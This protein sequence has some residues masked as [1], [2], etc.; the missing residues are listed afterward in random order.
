MQRSGVDAERVLPRVFCRLLGLQPKGPPTR[1]REHLDH[2]RDDPDALA[3]IHALAGQSARLLVPSDREDRTGAQPAVETVDGLAHGGMI[4][5]AHEALF[6]AWPELGRWIERR[7]EALLRQPQV[8]RDAERW[9][10]EGRP[11]GRIYKT[12]IITETREL[13]ESAEVWQ[14]L[15][16]DARIAHFLARDDADELAALARRA[17]DERMG[18]D[19]D[20]RRLDLLRTLTAEGRRADTVQTL[21]A[22]IAAEQSALADW[23]R[24]G[25]E[26]VIERF[27]DDLGEPWRWRRLRLGDLLA[28]IGD[29]REGVGLRDGLPDIVWQPVP[30]GD[31]QWQGGE[32]RKT[33]A[34][35]I[36]RYPVT[37]AQYQAFTEAEDYGDK[38]WWQEGYVGPEPARSTWNQPNRPRVNVAWV[39][40]LAY[41][42]WLTARFHERGLIDRNEAIRLP[43]EYE[44]EKAARGTDGRAFPWGED[45]RG[46]DAN[47]DETYDQTGLLFLRETTAVGL[48]PRNVSP[49][50]LIDCSGNV[51]EWCLNTYDDP[52]NIATEGEAMRALRGGSWDYDQAG[53]RA[54]AR[55]RLVILF[56]SSSVGFRLLCSVPI[57]H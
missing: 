10:A 15:A 32:T 31:F 2:W 23:L 11:D 14:C 12:D 43:T 20:V 21:G 56:R 5:V 47:I 7:R 49:Y 54:A 4:E 19:A 42:R 9:D 39:E 33:G 27:G 48:Y 30:E 3:L 36:A 17:F 41:C 16:Q 53:A 40:A 34:Y 55:Y 18:D 29:R 50:D 46:G 52:E 37:N 24:T 26:T 22:Q 45:Y 28:A 1:L 51:W 57:D 13:L 35:R 8:E 6:S 25:I 44:W 38:E